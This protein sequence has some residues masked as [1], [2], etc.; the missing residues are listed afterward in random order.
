MHRQGTHTA[1]GV[2]LLLRSRVTSNSDQRLEAVPGTK[3]AELVEE[4]V[5]YDGSG[6][7]PGARFLMIFERHLSFVVWVWQ[8]LC[9]IVFN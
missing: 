9:S 7:P 5:A 1:Y 6:A 8:M 4:N 3:P 2:G